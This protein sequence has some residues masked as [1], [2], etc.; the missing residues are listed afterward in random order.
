M[1]PFAD[2]DC[3][4]CNSAVS[5][6]YACQGTEWWHGWG[7][8][9]GLTKKRRCCFRRAHFASYPQ[10]IAGALSPGIKRPGSHN[11]HSQSS[12]AEIKNGGAIPPL[13]IRLLGV[14]LNELST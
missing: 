12:R 14:V 6:S 1:S 2:F 8:G 11:D 5:K 10:C 9:G 13:P 7:G 3:T 4:A